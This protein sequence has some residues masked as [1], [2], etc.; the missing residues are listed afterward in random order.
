VWCDVV[1]CGMVWYAVVWYGL[2]HGMVWWYCTSEG[3]RPLPPAPLN[4]MFRCF[5]V[6]M[7][8]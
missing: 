4:P 2:V 7:I 8:R 1:W 6:S 5:D 3:L